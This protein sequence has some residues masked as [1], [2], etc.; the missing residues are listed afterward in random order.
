MKPQAIWK[1]IAGDSRLAPL[2]V[3]V[4]I[5]VA[6]GMHAALPSGG[7]SLNGVVFV[8]VIAAGLVAGVFERV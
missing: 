6:L 8:A 2:G 1:F 3:A 7:G 5:G 4:A